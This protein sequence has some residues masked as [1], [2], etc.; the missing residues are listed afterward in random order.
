MTRKKV[1]VAYINDVNAR[2]ATFR[3]R[4]KGIMKKVNELTVLCGI[5][6]CAIIQNPFDSQIEVWP[7]PKG[8]KKVVERYM[9]TS[10]VDETKNMNQESFFVQ[11]ISKLQ[12]KLN[13]LRSENREKEMAL[14]M[15]EYFQT[16]KLPE[17][18]TLT[19]LKEMEKLIEQCVKETENKMVT[20]C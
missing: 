20:L 8:A 17:N 13:K 14:A 5:Q 11:R 18:L 16:K 2:K 9:S 15:L 3:K 7:N 19:D 4:K 10:K 12:G 1:K 6:G